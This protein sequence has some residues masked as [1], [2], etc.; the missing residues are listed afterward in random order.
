MT[1]RAH[2]THAR[3]AL[4]RCRCDPCR[5]AHRAYERARRA[6]LEPAYVSAGPARAH[7]LELSAAG[8]GWKHAAKVA[9]VSTGAVWKLMYGPSGRGPSKRIRRSTEQALLA[10]TPADA[11]PGAKIDAAP[12]WRLIDEMIAAGVPKV[13]IATGIGQKGPGLQLS[14][15]QV[16]ARNAAAVADLHARWRSGE[17]VLS[18]HDRHGN[19]YTATPPPAD[20]GRADVSDLLVELAEIIDA[21]RE[22]AGWRQ[23]AACRGRPG[24]L[25]FPAR[26]DTRTLEAGLAI[27]KACPVRDQCRSAHLDEPAGTYGALPAGRRR[28]LRQ[29][30]AA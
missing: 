21:R 27:C 3:Y 2:G 1:H 28:Q 14:R 19:T 16:S 7:L 4:D 15:R 11:A 29:E 18:R 12:T 25:W 23:H 20:R 6:R 10:V 22:H 5:D 17:L 24:Y 8:I 9:G 26:G 30:P 13:R